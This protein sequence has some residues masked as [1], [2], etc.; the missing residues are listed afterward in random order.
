MPEPLE[1]FV[2]GV[3]HKA[4]EIPV[5]GPEDDFF[6]IGGQSFKAVRIADE[7]G[8]TVVELFNNPTPRATARV[9][10]LNLQT[11]NFD[12]VAMRLTDNAGTGVGD[13]VEV[14]LTTRPPAECCRLPP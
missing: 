13:L 12:L 11:N 14:G 1:G 2:I 3:W 8:I 7:L 5:I 6:D 4:L 10:L 9:V